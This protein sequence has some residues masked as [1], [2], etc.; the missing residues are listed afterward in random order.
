MFIESQAIATKRVCRLGAP[1]IITG[2]IGLITFLR[3]ATPSSL[4]K[5]LRRSYHNIT[6]GRRA[7]N[8]TAD[9]GDKEGPHISRRT[10]Q[11]AHL[12]AILDPLSAD[13]TIKPIQTNKRRR[14][15]F[16]RR[17][18]PDIISKLRTVFWGYLSFAHQCSA[19]LIYSIRPCIRIV[20]ST[21]T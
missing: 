4:A 15:I 17:L 16:P 21:C 10:S 6:M 20:F 8:P 7:G 18:H 12:K 9:C 13:S 1:N 5:S 11:G 19:G 2:I 14:S 3:Y